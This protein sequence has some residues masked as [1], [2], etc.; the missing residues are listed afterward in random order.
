MKEEINRRYANKVSRRSLLLPPG[1]ASARRHTRGAG[2]ANSVSRSLRHAL[3]TSVTLQVIPD[4][5]L[6]VCLFD[7]LESSEGAVL[8]GDGCFYYKGE[9]WRTS[10]A[11]HVLTTLLQLDSVSSS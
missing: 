1:C 4:A 9:L 11:L 7:I 3:T 6:C 10:H 5:G 2:G 8:Y